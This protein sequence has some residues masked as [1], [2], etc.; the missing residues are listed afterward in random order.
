[1]NERDLLP[2]TMNLAQ[3]QGEQHE[4]QIQISGLSNPSG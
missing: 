4:T 2:N 3:L 1:M